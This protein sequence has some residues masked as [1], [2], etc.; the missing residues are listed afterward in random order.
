MATP[1]VAAIWASWCK[2]ASGCCSQP[3]TRDCTSVAP[4]SLRWR[5]IQP[6]DIAS[7][8]AVV[9]KSVWRVWARPVT[10]V[11]EALLKVGHVSCAPI[12]PEVLL[13]V[14]AENASTSQAKVDAYGLWDSQPLG[15]K[16]T[17]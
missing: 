10:L 8:S 11:M 13:L 16:L 4:L 3:S 7:W 9:V 5:R 2:L 14:S 17:V 6:V 12:L 1:R 15:K